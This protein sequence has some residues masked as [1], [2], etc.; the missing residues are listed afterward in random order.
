MILGLNTDVRHKGKTFHIQTED[1]GIANPVLFTHVFLG[2]TIIASRKS[3]YEDD[4]EHEALEKHVRGLMRAQHRATHDALVAGEFDD[5][6]KKA[7]TRTKKGDIPLAK[8][9][10]PVGVMSGP[11][12]HEPRTVSSPPPEDVI[13]ELDAEDLEL[14]DDDASPER[15]ATAPPPPPAEAMTA[16]RPDTLDEA[17]AEVDD[18]VG[19]DDVDDAVEATPPAPDASPLVE[20]PTD[21]ISGRPLDPVVVAWLLE[22]E[23]PT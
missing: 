7:R 12:R 18:A 20:Y 11:P 8:K 5:A 17:P 19:V 1:S 13:E 23:P 4:L 16:R 2:G 14:L 9:K 10:G 3:S 21:L 22:D 15:P 6:A